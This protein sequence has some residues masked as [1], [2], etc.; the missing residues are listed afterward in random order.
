MSLAAEVRAAFEHPPPSWVAAFV[1]DPVASLTELFA[2]RWYHGR[3]NAEDP[4]RL[5]LD[6]ADG[7]SEV[8]G[9]PELLDE[10]LA[11]WIRERWRADLDDERPELKWQRAL[12]VAATLHDQLPETLTELRARMTE[13]PDVL[14]PMT[15]GITLDP[16]GWYWTCLAQ[17]Q[18]DTELTQQWWALSEL[19]PGTPWF[20]GRIGLLGLRRL[21][22]SDIGGFR[23]SAAFALLRLANALD[24]QVEARMIKQTLAQR[25]ARAAARELRRSYPFPTAWDAFWSAHHGELDE[26]PHSWLA[27]VLGEPRSQRRA[28]RGAGGIT[29]DRSWPRRTKEIVQRL[30]R[31]DAVAMA[32]AEAL[33]AEQRRY[34]AAT[35]DRG[36]V[37]RAL[38]ALSSALLFADPPT[39]LAWADE[40]RQ[41][42]E[43]NPFAWTSTVR[44]LSAL[45]SDER[46]LV[47]ALEAVERFP[48]DVVARAGLADVLKARGD[49]DAAETTYRDTIERFPDDVV[50]RAGLADVLKARGDLDAAETTYRDT[51]ERFPD[52]DFAR[53]GLADVLKARG[54]LDAAETTYRDTIVQ[55]PDDVVARTSLADVLRARGDLAAAEAAYSDALERF[56]DDDYARTGLAAVR[57]QRA[58]RQS[59]DASSTSGPP[60]SE[61]GAQPHEPRPPHEAALDRDAGHSQAR[62][63]HRRGTSPSE[64]GAR[65]APDA[66]AIPAAD[67]IRSMLLLAR[68]KSGSTRTAL[69]AQA[70]EEIDDQ[71]ERTP[72]H[73]ELLFTK[74]EVL[75]ESE[76]PNDA[77]ELLDALPA[78]V[79]KRPEFLALDGRLALDEM[80]RQPKQRYDAAQLNSVMRPWVQA[81]RQHSALGLNVPLVRLQASSLV[82]DGEVLEEVRHETLRELRGLVTRP[83]D[84]PSSKRAPH[85]NATLRTW[86]RGRLADALPTLDDADAEVSYSDAESVLVDRPDLLDKLERELI[87]ASRFTSSAG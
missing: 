19:A 30:R 82:Y 80:R 39:A 13:A 57:R 36:G 28:S 60:E 66:S 43:W 71:L 22:G 35:G 76:L 31:R 14:G 33:L 49:L 83:D 79:A 38:C 59:T 65:M 7:L 75:L 32:E 68:L 40:A 27:A 58:A 25:A 34:A 67:R 1:E 9:F 5:L 10:S 29:F 41:W 23:E 20:H 78:Y 62:A 45:G 56:P 18:I 46:A 52:N 12:L 44:A 85:R 77:R 6:W 55:F 50:A 3:L 47:A 51:I 54:D 87:D 11:T 21:P 74:V 61:P 8:P 2:G 73:V 48:D 53:N 64:S 15:R 24:A 37:V 26:R 42:D 17:Q 84:E 69:L 63:E 4:E 81:G 86:W 70:R 72:R 16:M